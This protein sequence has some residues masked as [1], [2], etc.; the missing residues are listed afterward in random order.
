MSPGD[1]SFRRTPRSRRYLVSFGISY[2]FSVSLLGDQIPLVGRP[3]G[4]PVVL[5]N[6]DKHRREFFSKRTFPSVQHGV[7][8]ILALG[9]PCVVAARIYLPLTLEYMA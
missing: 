7:P 1:L 3:V 5:K 8:G 9:G 4:K 6:L 2:T